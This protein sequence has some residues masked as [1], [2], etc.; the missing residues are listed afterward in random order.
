MVALHLLAAQR[1]AATSM[2][3]VAHQATL[4]AL[5]VVLLGFTVLDTVVQPPSQAV[6]LV[7]V[8]QAPLMR[9]EGL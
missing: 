5:A 8:G 6:G 3:R 4:R 2:C 7:L 9:A 1:Q